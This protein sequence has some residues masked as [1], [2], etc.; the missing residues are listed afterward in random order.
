MSLT[1][2]MNMVS[3]LQVKFKQKLNIKELKFEMVFVKIFKY[4]KKDQLKKH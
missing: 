2:F 1:F 4:V 3:E